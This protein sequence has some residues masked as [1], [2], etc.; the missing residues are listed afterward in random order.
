MKR[1]FTVSSVLMVFAFAVIVAMFMFVLIENDLHNSAVSGLIVE[2]ARWAVDA[3]DYACAS[4]V[5]G[6]VPW[7]EGAVNTAIGE[8]RDNFIDELNVSG[9]TYKRNDLPWVRFSNIF[10]ISS[11]D[12]FE[13]Y[14]GFNISYKYNVAPSI[15]LSVPASGSSPVIPGDGLFDFTIR[16]CDP[17]N[18]SSDMRFWL[19]SGPIGCAGPWTALEDVSGND[20]T[21]VAMSS[22]PFL[23]ANL[24]NNPGL[25]PFCFKA[26]ASDQGKNSTE[27]FSDIVNL[28]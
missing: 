11:L 4:F 8:S 13:K 23:E 27:S 24:T 7:S 10:P 5:D 22:P 19:Y 12:F 1:G 26:V 17:D 25:G 14:R 9:N 16:F 3:E 28:A 2:R 15:R 18:S 6:V 21:D 20:L